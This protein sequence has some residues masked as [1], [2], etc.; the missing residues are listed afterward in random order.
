MKNFIDN[1]EMK[2]KELLGIIKKYI[3]VH[4]FYFAPMKDDIQAF[5]VHTG[6]IFFNIKYLREY[7]D[8]KNDNLKIIIRE[9][10]ILIIFHELNHGLT[11]EID[12]SKKIIFLL[13]VK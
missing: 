7:F 4:N 5:T 10:I 13:L 6:D 11:R 12:L 8:E 9:K 3:E 2:S 1:Y